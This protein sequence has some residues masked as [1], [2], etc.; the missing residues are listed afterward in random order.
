MLEDKM[1]FSWPQ[2]RH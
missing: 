2:R 1:S